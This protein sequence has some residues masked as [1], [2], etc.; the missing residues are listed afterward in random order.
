MW[1][2]QNI[3]ALFLRLLWKTVQ[4]FLKKK[5]KTELPYDPAIPLSDI[6]IPKE[7]KAGSLRH[8]CTTI[9]KAALFTGAKTWKHLKSPPT[10]DW[11]K[12]TV[13]YTYT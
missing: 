1:R 12:Q 3:F 5:L 9:F 13:V 2:N 10:N 8:I 6:Y 7:L 4:W 11:T